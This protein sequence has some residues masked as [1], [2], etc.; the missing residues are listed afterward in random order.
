MI[1]RGQKAGIFNPVLLA[2]HQTNGYVRD[3]KAA[4]ISKAKRLVKVCTVGVPIFL[5]DSFIYL[6]NLK[7]SLE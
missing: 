1:I 2:G 7:V 4:K 6:K 5:Q 3:G